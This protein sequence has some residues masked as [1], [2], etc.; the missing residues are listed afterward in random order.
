[1]GVSFEGVSAVAAALDECQTLKKK[2]EQWWYAM[3]STQIAF[4]FYFPSI[5]S[6]GV[7]KYDFLL[8][9]FKSSESTKLAN[10]SNVLFQNVFCRKG[11]IE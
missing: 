1:V 6:D 10:I 3:M 9:I 5:F 2:K 8:R 11:S 4:F 7:F